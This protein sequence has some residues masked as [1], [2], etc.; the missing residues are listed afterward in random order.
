MRSFLVLACCL[1]LIGC[2]T[3]GGTSSAGS[4]PSGGPTRIS[5]EGGDGSSTAQAVIIKGARN[6][7]DGVRSEYSW[8]QQHFPG[9]RPAQQGLINSNG[10]AYDSVTFTLAN[11]ERRTVFFDIGE[12]FGKF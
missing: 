3:T 8:I 10:R 7:S 2:Q 1:L 9:S 12:F 11:G 4:I 5:Y 6:E